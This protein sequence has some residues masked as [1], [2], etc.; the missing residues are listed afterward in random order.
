MDCRVADPA[1]LLLL[2]VPSMGCSA[3]EEKNGSH[4]RLADRNATEVRTWLC[5]KREGRGDDPTEKLRVTASRTA[6]PPP[7]SGDRR[8]NLKS[9]PDAATLLA[10]VGPGGDGVIAAAGGR[11]ESPTQLGSTTAAVVH[12][13]CRTHPGRY[14]D[15]SSLMLNSRRA[16]APCA[17]VPWSNVQVQA[18][19]A[20]EIFRAA[21]SSPADWRQRRRQFNV[22]SSCRR[23]S[24]AVEPE[25]P[26]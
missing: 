24:S 19:T 26:A 8:Q 4:M 5:A 9:P 11:H 7:L 16:S 22:A 10:R 2:Q 17:P 14:E 18:S 15:V 13:G 25:G 12:T 3:M 21:P 20:G 1:R 23:Q 6:I